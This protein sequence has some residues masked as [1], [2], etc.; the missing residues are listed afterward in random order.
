[1]ISWLGGEI[2]RCVWQLGLGGRS[3]GATDIAN[4][5][6]P[7]SRFALPKVTTIDPSFLNKFKPGLKFYRCPSP[8][9][10]WQV[11]FS[12]LPTVLK[13]WKTDN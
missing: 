4:T 2:R 7:N 6:A 3:A 12:G 1:M 9:L 5:Q 8:L 13:M 10:W 11:R